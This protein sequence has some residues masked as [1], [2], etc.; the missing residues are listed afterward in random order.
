MRDRLEKTFAS[1]SKRHQAV[2]SRLSEIRSSRAQLQ[3]QSDRA[4]ARLDRAN[5]ILSRTRII[6]KEF[7][8]LLRYQHQWQSLTSAVERAVADD[9]VVFLT[10]DGYVCTS[11]TDLISGLTGSGGGDGGALE[12]FPLPAA[13]PHV[14]LS[15]EA[16]A[17]ELKSI[18][19]IQREVTAA[20]RAREDLGAAVASYMV[21]KNAF[22]GQFEDALHVRLS[23][24]LS[25]SSRILIGSYYSA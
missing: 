9:K 5:K 3:R 13:S 19:L 20:M 24:S 16:E 22:V 11:M 25:L 14:E 10:A 21:Q 8:R 17:R 18:K 12:L 4:N 7:E 6:A 15:A 23:L 1:L 2:S